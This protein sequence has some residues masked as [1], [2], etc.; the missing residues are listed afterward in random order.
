MTKI[1]EENEDKSKNNY[2]QF[3]RESLLCAF[4]DDCVTPSLSLWE[5]EQFTSVECHQSVSVFLTLMRSFFSSTFKV[6]HQLCSFSL[7]AE[8]LDGGRRILCD[9]SLIKC[10]MCVRISRGLHELVFSRPQV[11]PPIR[12]EGSLGKSSLPGAHFLRIN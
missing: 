2:L 4:S 12:G 9:L 8:G 1:V 6:I 5:S 7:M 3:G 10:G 11:L